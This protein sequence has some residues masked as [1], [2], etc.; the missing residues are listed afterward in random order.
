VANASNSVALGAGSIVDG[1]DNTVSVGNAEG[2]FYRTISNVAPGVLDTDAVNMGQLRHKIHNLDRD[3]SGGIAAAAAQMNVMPYVPGVFAVAMSGASYNGQ[4]AIGATISRWDCSGKWN[5]NGGVSYG[6]N[7]TP[8][9]RGAV[10]YLFGTPP[11][12]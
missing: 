6:F 4:G 5:L 11:A 12:K 9:F 2:G 1:R 8:I 10:T 3:L 7:D